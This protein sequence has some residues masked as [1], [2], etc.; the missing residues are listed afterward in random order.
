MNRRFTEISF[1]VSGE[2][3]GWWLWLHVIWMW[4]GLTPSLCIYIFN[5]R[6]CEY[7]WV[8]VWMYVRIPFSERKDNHGELTFLCWLRNEHSIKCTLNQ[9]LSSMFVL[10]V[11]FCVGV[12]SLF[13]FKCLWKYFRCL[14]VRIL[15]D[16]N[17]G[18][19][20]NERRKI[21]SKIGK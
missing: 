7:G 11:L 21:R 17:I 20:F 4:N 10:L 12:L 16:E 3:G 8:Y 1:I 13:V 18:G 6:L 9:I 15:F 19:K 14:F 5:M 2:S